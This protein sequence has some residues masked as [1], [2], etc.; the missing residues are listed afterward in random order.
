MHKDVTF[1]AEPCALYY[2]YS[3]SKITMLSCG[4]FGCVKEIVICDHSKA[5]VPDFYLEKLLLCLCACTFCCFLY[6][7]RKST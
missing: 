1:M 2:I 7:Y 3:V 4:V 6:A 5:Y